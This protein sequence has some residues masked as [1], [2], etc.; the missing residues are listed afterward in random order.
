M[1]NNNKMV[2]INI[3]IHKLL[4]FFW[5]IQ[6][7]STVIHKNFMNN[8]PKYAKRKE[9]VFSTD[10]SEM[11]LHFDFCVLK[12]GISLFLKTPSAVLA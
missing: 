8:P 11:G 3:F 10:I 6:K 5:K 12:G 2:E 1:K 9:R 4:F 7:L